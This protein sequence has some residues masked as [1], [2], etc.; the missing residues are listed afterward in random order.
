M[1]RRRGCLDRALVFSSVHGRVAR[2]GLTRAGCGTPAA[3]YLY[4]HVTVCCT[5]HPSTLFAATRC[6]DDMMDGFSRQDRTELGS[7]FKAPRSMKVMVTPSP[8]DHPRSCA[9]NYERPARVF[10]EED[11]LEILKVGFESK[12][13]ATQ[14]DARPA[15]VG[16]LTRQQ[17]CHRKNKTQARAYR[18]RSCGL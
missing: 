8:S 6:V 18:R 11:L 10:S 14:A 9:A 4:R 1:A 17:L 5:R 7:K 13:C 12:D 2:W 16:E 15:R 3:T